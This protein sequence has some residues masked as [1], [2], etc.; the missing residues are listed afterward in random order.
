[1]AQNGKLKLDLVDVFGKRLQENVDVS[2]RNLQLSHAPVLRG[3]DASRIINITNLHTGAQGVYQISI[4]PPS[5]H[6]VSLF[7]NI[8]TSGDTQLTIPF[9]VDINKI[10]SVTFPTFPNLLKD[11]RTLLTNSPNVFGF[12][13]NI[14]E[15]LYQS[16][17]RDDIR[18]A[19]VLNIARKTQATRLANDKTCLSLIKEI[20]ELRGDRF[21]AFVEKELREEVKHGVNTGLF[22]KVD[23]SQH[24]LPSQFVGFERAGSF[25]TGDA[26][27]N[28]QLTF[29]VKG[30]DW[31]ADIDID[32]ANGLAHI[33]QVLRNHFTGN[34]THPYNIH[35]ILLQ[36]QHL[37][38]GYRFNLK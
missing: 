7:V 2:L 37:D 24:H 13:N 36:H 20:R 35:Q 38:P 14:G 1:M 5:Y 4:D 28:L 34:P 11:L 22:D 10:V 31:V 25:K 19:G 3:L 8:K 16:L 29:F 6:P 27:G 12:E 32:D 17:A 26:Y 23:E 21:F 18:R 15:A 30:D 33:F 9:P